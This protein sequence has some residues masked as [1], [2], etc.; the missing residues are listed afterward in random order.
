M[1]EYLVVS[2]AQSGVRFPKDAPLILEQFPTEL[3]RVDIIIQTRLAPLAGISKPVPMG[4][5]AEVRGSAPSLDDAVQEFSRAV[6]SLC[7]VFSFIG[8]STIEDMVPEIGYEVTPGVTDRDFFQQFLSEERLLII[9]RRRIPTDLTVRILDNFLHHAEAERIRRALAQYYQ[10]LRNWEPGQ[11]VLAVAHLWMGV[12]ALTPVVVRRFALEQK[13]DRAGMASLWQVDERQVEAEARRLLIMQGDSDAYSTA[14]RASD[15][16]EHG[17][18]GFLELR[19]HADQVRLKVA[20]YLRQ[21]IINELALDK[22]DAAALLAPPFNIPGHLGLAKY[23]RGKLI[24]PTEE[25]AAPDQAYPFLKWTTKFTE[26]GEPNDE[27]VKVK[28]EETITGVFA[29]GVRFQPRRVE[30]WGGQEST[31]KRDGV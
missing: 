21:A 4:L 19:K 8:N 24:A 25:I 10:A 22:S 13:I 5:M 12:E 16:F 26:V 11:E 15:G 1:P 7:P 29:K 6:Q 28:M 17:Y 9:E 2:R 20:E 18:L 27:D 14:R 31:L 23:L 3:G 30:V